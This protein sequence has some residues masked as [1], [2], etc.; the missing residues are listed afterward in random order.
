[1]KG[2][3]FLGNGG[4]HTFGLQFKLLATLAALFTAFVVVAAIW[5]VSF[6][7][8]KSLADAEN[9]AIALSDQ[10]DAV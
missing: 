3:R 7:H 2:W 9:R 1:M 5:G 4:K 6:V 10:M 8:D